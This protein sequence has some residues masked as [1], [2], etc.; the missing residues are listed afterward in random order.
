MNTSTKATLKVHAVEV[1]DAKDRHV[2]THLQPSGK[3]WPDGERAAHP[4]H[5]PADEHGVIY[6]EVT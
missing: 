4:V 6:H 5:G 2:R 1:H 3:Y